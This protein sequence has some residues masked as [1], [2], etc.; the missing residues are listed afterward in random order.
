MLLFK[1]KFQKKNCTHLANE[2]KNQIYSTLV[3]EAFSRVKEK[4]I[5]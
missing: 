3:G 4:K 2:K 1:D 5:M